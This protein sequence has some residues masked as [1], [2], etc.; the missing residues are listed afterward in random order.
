MA[1]STATKRAVKSSSR[2]PLKS[3]P[4][5]SA[6]EPEPRYPFR[7]P[8][9]SL[10]PFLATLPPTHIYLIHTDTF[11]PSH[12]RRIFAV[13]LILN[14]CLAL[15]LLWRAYHAVPSYFAILLA[16]LGF[17]NRARVDIGATDWPALLEIGASRTG[18]FFLDFA[19]VRFVAVWPVDFFWG[20]PAG[21][22]RWRREVGFCKAEVVVRRSRRWGEGV[23]GDDQE[24]MG[25]GKLGAKAFE[26]RVIPGMN[27]GWVRGRSGMAM[28]DKN[29]DLWFRGMVDAHSMV[30]QGKMRMEHFEGR[31]VAV[32]TEEKG[33]LVWQM[34]GDDDGGPARR[35][36]QLVK[37]RLE[38]LGKE[39]LFWSWV[40]LV[41]FETDRATQARATQH[42]H[43]G[44]GSARADVMQRGKRLFE[45]H[46]VDFD[47][48]WQG[49]GGMDDMPGMA[50]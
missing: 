1:K 23:V 43:D 27:A 5:N 30:E 21:P 6:S 31:T 44:A 3:F 45:A 28:L 24:V 10:V 36:I 15:L 48:F 22:M 14:V 18:M 41:Q 49:V 37:A 19:L 38:A 29:W 17:D 16:T 40:E 35:K 47:D 39:S 11:P 25:E 42:G 8:S 13:P 46:G 7:P 26:E 12:K 20:T 33:W 2:T 34:E 32:H 4:S 9:S 50:A